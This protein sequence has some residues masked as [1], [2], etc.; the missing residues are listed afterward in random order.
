MRQFIYGQNV[1]EKDTIRIVR[2][3]MKGRINKMA[4]KKSAGN[5][6]VT[7]FMQGR[8]GYD[9]LSKFLIVL[10][11]ILLVATVFMQTAFM[12][13]WAESKYMY[14]VAIIVLAC[15]YGRMA[16]KNIKKRK[17]ENEAYLRFMS[18]FS[19]K[20]QAQ[21]DRE[22]RNRKYATFE[23]SK[24]LGE[25]GIVYSVYKCRGCGSEQRFAENKG[26]IK[27]ICPECGNELVDRT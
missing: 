6:T 21:L 18:R 20:A 15:G 11:M 2:W 4:K 1:T 23:M 10:A 13:M 12:D 9:Q 26:V 14:I 8:Y 3:N 22:E 16:S 25:D 17:A 27:I 5:K 7:E 24:E 19:K